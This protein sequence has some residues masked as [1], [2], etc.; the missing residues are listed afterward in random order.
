[1]VVGGDKY[2]LEQNIPSLQQKLRK[3]TIIK[4]TWKTPDLEKNYRR[5]KNEKLQRKKSIM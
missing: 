1:M 3:K 4:F 5:E 2:V